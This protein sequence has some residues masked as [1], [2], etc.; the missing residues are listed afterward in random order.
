MEEFE[1]KQLR[2]LNNISMQE[3]LRNVY[4]D[5]EKEYE[6]QSG[7]ELMKYNM[8]KQDKEWMKRIIRSGTFKDKVSALSIYI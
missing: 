1:K 4:K 8:S 5:A 7:R 3:K 6:I 2:L